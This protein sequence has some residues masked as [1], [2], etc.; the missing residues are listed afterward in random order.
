MII[1][2]VGATGFLG[3]NLVYHLLD[4]TKHSIVAISRHATGTNFNASSNPRLTTVDADIFDEEQMTEALLGADVA[5]FFVH[6]MGQKNKDFYTQEAIAAHRFSAAALAA[7]VN[8]VIY[9]G[10][11]GNDHDQLSQHL[12]S[13]HNTGTVLRENLPLVLELRAAMIIGKGS[14]SFDIIQ[15]LVHKLPFMTLPRWSISLTQPIALQDMLDYLTLSA[16]IP[17][18]HHEIV[19]VGGPDVLS[20]KDLYRAYASSVG[21][22]PFIIRIPFLPEWLGGWWLNLFTPKGHAK[23]GRIMVHSMSNAMVVTHDRAQQL[24]PSVHPVSVLDA[25]ALSSSSKH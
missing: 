3:K 8:R 10:G 5:Y 22:H 2:I 6:M 24:F 25:I 1:A 11:L 4:T 21:R 14:V 17:L 13:R 15:N 16:V 12:L 9:M 23:I 19:E 20:Y 7:N 18:T